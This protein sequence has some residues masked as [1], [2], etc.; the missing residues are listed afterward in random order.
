VKKP[1]PTRKIGWRGTPEERFWRFVRKT[2]TCWNWSGTKDRLGYTHFQSPIS[3]LAHVFSFFLHKGS[4]P[5]GLEIDHLCRNRG[6]VNPDHLE[7]VTRKQN[8][9]R[10]AAAWPKKTHCKRGHPFTG[11]NDR[12]SLDGKRKC[13]ICRIELQRISRSKHSLD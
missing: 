9:E 3:Q 1:P 5:K 8:M 6:C 7:A 13:H 2:E 10:A 4:I 11:F 12:F